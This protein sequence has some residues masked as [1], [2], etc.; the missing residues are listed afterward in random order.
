MRKMSNLLQNEGFATAFLSFRLVSRRLM[1]CHSMSVGKWSLCPKM[2]VGSAWPAGASLLLSVNRGRIGIFLQSQCQCPLWLHFFISLLSIAFWLLMVKDNMS[3]VY[4]TFRRPHILLIFR[5]FIFHTGLQLCSVI[6]SVIPE[7]KNLWK[8][9]NLALWLQPAAK[10]LVPPPQ[11]KNWC[12]VSPSTC[13][14]GDK[15]RVVTERRANTWWRDA[16]TRGIVVL[17]DIMKSWFPEREWTKLV[18]VKIR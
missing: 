17:C 6:S 11:E 13:L 5:C 1:W 15:Q 7:K 4:F 18:K 16:V 14:E 9:V 8:T 12:F 3:L 10:R 2:N